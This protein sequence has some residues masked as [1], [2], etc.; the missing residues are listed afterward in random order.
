MAQRKNK[1][2]EF[3]LWMGPLLDALRDLGDSG[4]PREVSDLIATNLNISDEKK[5]E[6]IDAEMLMDMME[7][8]EIG[9]KPK[10]VFEID[11][12]FFAQYM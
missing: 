10:I 6:L 11:N 1:K 12:T 2:A 7:K 4:S 9:L 8:E 5:E 3:V